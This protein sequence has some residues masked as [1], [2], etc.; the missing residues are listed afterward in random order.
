MICPRCDSPSRVTHTKDGCE[1]VRRRTCTEC[2]HKF[3][4]FERSVDEQVGLDAKF[5]KA[6]AETLERF[7]DVEASIA[8]CSTKKPRG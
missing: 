3:K 7:E 8:T 6:L 5:R 4:T 2:G 1:V